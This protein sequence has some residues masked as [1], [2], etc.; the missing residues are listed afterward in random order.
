LSFYLDKNSKKL[1]F[2]IRDGF[3]YG[4]VWVSVSLLLVPYSYFEIGENPNPYPNP[5]KMGKP[6][7]GRIKK[8]Y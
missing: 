5:I 3:M 2:Y 4:L 6:I 1:I 7:D 8:V